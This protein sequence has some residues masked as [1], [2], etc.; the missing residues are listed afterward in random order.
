MRKS[1]AKPLIRRNF[2]ALRGPPTPWPYQED[3]QSPKFEVDARFVADNGRI[4]TAQRGGDGFVDP[5]WADDLERQGTEPFTRASNRLLFEMA[6][7]AGL[8][9][10]EEVD[11]QLGATQ[12]L[13][14]AHELDAL[15]HIALDAPAIY[16]A[17]KEEYD[18]Y[19]AGNGTPPTDEIQYG[20][21]SG[22]EA[23]DYS[24]AAGVWWIGLHADDIDGSPWGYHSATRL[25][26]MSAGSEAYYVNFCN[27]GRCPY[28]SG[29]PQSC[30]RGAYTKSAFQVWNCN[31]PY[32]LYS[33]DGGHN[34]H[35]DSRLQ[36]ASFEYGTGDQLDPG[37]QYWCNGAD[38][39]TDISVDIF[40][41][42][43]DQDGYPTC[44]YNTN[45]GLDHTAMCYYQTPTAS[46]WNAAAGCYCDQACVT[47]NDCCLDGP[48]W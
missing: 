43:L 18:E 38:D 24:A 33:D 29:M 45:R 35:D 17:M 4:F 22:P 19:L 7:E 1:H 27:H 40:G 32:A 37:Y 28:E 48:W 14:L 46:G 36:M 42:E 16:A 44:D 2:E 34:C 13:A 6:A 47:Y 10:D 30:S 15:C 5:T 8:V 3:P 26:A 25:H 31:T 21:A 12:A 11:R 41:W 20:S 9:L 23:S 39:S